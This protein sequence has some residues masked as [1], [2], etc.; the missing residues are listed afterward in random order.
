MENPYTLW[1]M[2]TPP[3]EYEGVYQEWDFLDARHPANC[4]N[5]TFWCHS[6]PFAPV[7]DVTLRFKSAGVG[8][9]IENITGDDREL[10]IAMCQLIGARHATAT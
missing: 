1:R 3:I 7:W 6:S 4:A 10:L 5:V 8:T 2:R 9:K